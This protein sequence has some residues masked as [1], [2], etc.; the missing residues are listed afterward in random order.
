MYAM[1]I[2][3]HSVITNY[4]ASNVNGEIIMANTTTNTKPWLGNWA[5]NN[6]WV[7]IDDEFCA[8]RVQSYT[9]AMG[10]VVV[11]FFIRLSLMISYAGGFFI[12]ATVSVADGSIEH[13]RG[14]RSSVSWTLAGNRS[15]C[16]VRILLW[17]GSIS[18][19]Y[20]WCMAKRFDCELH[21]KLPTVPFSIS[22]AADSVVALRLRFILNRWSH[23]R[24]L[25]TSYVCRSGNG[26]GGR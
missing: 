8:Y 17:L 9:L 15:K 4:W 21:V 20:S 2:K 14:D 25:T 26:L 6:Q 3:S 19:S 16:T 7:E 12:G 1:S 18:L 13:F 5:C 23:S 24:P 10:T 11:L 22:N